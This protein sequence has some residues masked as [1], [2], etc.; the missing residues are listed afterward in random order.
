MPQSVIDFDP[1]PGT[2]NSNP[3]L[4]SRIDLQVELAKRKRSQW[5]R[6]EPGI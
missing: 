4:A 3:S 2:G 6:E 5:D 1:S